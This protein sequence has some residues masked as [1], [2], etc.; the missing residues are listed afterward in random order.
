LVNKNFSFLGV[1]RHLFSEN[2]HQRLEEHPTGYPCTRIGK[3]RHGN[4][5]VTALH[6]IQ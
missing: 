4:S 2:F 1:V 5:Q 3:I 6:S